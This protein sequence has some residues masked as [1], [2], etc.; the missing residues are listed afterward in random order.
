MAA[1]SVSVPWIP[2]LTKFGVRRVIARQ[3]AGMEIDHPKWCSSDPD[4]LWARLAEYAPAFYLTGNGSLF[5]QGHAHVVGA[6]NP[7]DMRFIDGA[8]GNTMS[9]NA[10]LMIQRYHYSAINPAL[11]VI[12][13]YTFQTFTLASGAGNQILMRGAVG[14]WLIIWANLLNW[15]KA[16]L[17]IPQ[18]MRARSPPHGGA[19]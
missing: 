11:R 6:K 10:D 4:M 9:N 3:F 5:L 7:P 2:V 13:I 12:A 17:D 8:R 16:P 14:L 19:G 1:S 18:W 15:H